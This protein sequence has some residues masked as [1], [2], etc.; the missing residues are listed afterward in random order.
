MVRM[1]HKD[2]SRFPDGVEMNTSKLGV[3]PVDLLLQWF[4]DFRDP[5]AKPAV[6]S[7]C[8]ANLTSARNE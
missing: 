6:K 4:P 5:E 8:S 3:K 7:T 1:R 2:D